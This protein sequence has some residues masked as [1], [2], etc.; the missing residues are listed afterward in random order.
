VI[1]LIGELD[2][3]SEIGNYNNGTPPNKFI[4]TKCFDYWNNC[5]K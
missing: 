3:I 4:H 2:E 5:L 1:G